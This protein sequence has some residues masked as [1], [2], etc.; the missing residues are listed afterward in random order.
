[1]SSMI[2]LGNWYYRN[3]LYPAVLIKDINIMKINFY[4][5]QGNIYI[6]NN[7]NKVHIAFFNFSHNNMISN[8]DFRNK[9]NNLKVGNNYDII[10]VVIDDSY[11]SDID[12]YYFKSIMYHI[13]DIIFTE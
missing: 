8:D 9:I 4:I 1:M 2:E 12:P 6:T 3:K 11:I 5:N 7:P 10:C 13:I